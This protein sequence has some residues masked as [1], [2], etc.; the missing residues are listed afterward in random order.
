MRAGSWCLLVG[1]LL[2]LLLLQR[3]QFGPGTFLF[4]LLPHGR[5]LDKGALSHG[6]GAKLWPFAF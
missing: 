2:L 6:S 4:H 1:L 5:I 3:H